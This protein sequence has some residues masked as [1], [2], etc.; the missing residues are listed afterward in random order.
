[1]RVIG[2][3]PVIVV[4][5][6]TTAGSVQPAPARAAITTL[7][8][9]V[10]VRAGALATGR[11]HLLVSPTTVAP[12]TTLTIAGTGYAAGEPVMA[13]LEGIGL[14]TTPAL[15]TADA[16]GNFIA[17]ATV[18][19]NV[20]SG[21]APLIVGGARSRA[22]AQTVVEVQ[23]PI[24]ATWYFAGL[25]TRVGTRDAIA[26]LNPDNN[27]ARVT[28]HL[29]RAD[30]P[31]DDRSLTLGGHSR[32]TL[33]LAAFAG[34]RHALLFVRLTADRRVAAAAA[35]ARRPRLW[36]GA[37]GVSVPRRT[38]YL[39]EG[40][41][42][43]TTHE[44]LRLYNP[45]PT[46]AR[47]A[48]RLLPQTGPSRLVQVVLG[49][50]RGRELAIDSYVR[51]QAVG[52]IIQASTSV[53][54]QRF[55]TFGP[56]DAGATA[57][58]GV[59]ETAARWTFPV[60]LAPDGARTFYA[61]VDPDPG[62]P[63]A[64]TAT[65][66]DARGRVAARATAVMA[67]L[68]RATIAAP[69]AGRDATTVVLTSNIPVV[70]ERTVLPASTG[71]LAPP[72]GYTVGPATPAVVQV[73]PDGN[74]GAG[75]GEYLV[76][77]NA[78]G[79]AA[80][81]GVEFYTTRGTATHTGLTVSA[82]AR[83]VVVVNRVAGLSAG[84]H[85]AVVLSSGVPVFVEQ[86]IAP[87]A[88]RGQTRP[89]ARP[90]HPPRPTRRSP[91]HPTRRSPPRPTRSC[92]IL[93][94][95]AAFPP[96][97]TQWVSGL[98]TPNVGA[99]ASGLQQAHYSWGYV[100]LTPDLYPTVAAAQR[101]Y[102]Q[103]SRMLYGSPQAQ[104]HAPLIGQQMVVRVTGDQLTHYTVTT[105]LIRAR[106]TVAEINVGAGGPVVAVAADIARAVSASACG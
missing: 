4:A 54:V 30:G 60:G 66:Y 57:S 87:V 73:F 20:V 48:V 49:G 68:H 83:T 25:D 85:G 67:P 38:W 51:R 19:D 17:T 59:A 11:P 100:V 22:G 65:F 98:T 86:R 88:P 28:L 91:T 3:I 13:T 24:A 14:A 26:V 44:Y 43:T 95:R 76:V 10:S 16:Q 8:S 103:A 96:H 50:D 58:V 106:T 36:G 74:T 64:V 89:P 78:T 75:Y 32:S 7:V 93:L 27:P 18:P 23:R 79:Q 12:G 31:A 72:E 71:P 5:L 61:V 63:A 35:A 47:V 15:V 99:A 101:R 40:Y 2:A 21:P 62:A 29:A 56:H 80:R 90:T 39:A 104:T 33:D 105:I 82:R 77:Q 102:Q 37:P 81:V 70:A 34:G 45:S 94:P 84:E 92:T 55:S 53:V 6:T 42:D 46:T 52:A 69:A 9:S 1:M 41:V 97:I